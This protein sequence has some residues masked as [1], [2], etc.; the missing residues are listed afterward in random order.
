MKYQDLG[1][2]H[3]LTDYSCILEVKMLGIDVLEDI[4]NVP[5]TFLN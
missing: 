4:K 3:I 5:M 2:V 1:I